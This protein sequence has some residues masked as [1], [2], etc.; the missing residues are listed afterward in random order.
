MG[1][2]EG[3]AFSASSVYSSFFQLVSLPWDVVK[4]VCAVSCVE[5]HIFYPV[6]H[7]RLKK[8]NLI[9]VLE[10]TYHYN[11]WFHT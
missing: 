10:H 7:P 5:S 4:N 2:V 8:K 11:P 6:C 1:K 3:L 9:S